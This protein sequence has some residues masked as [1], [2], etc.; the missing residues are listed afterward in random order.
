M[1]PQQQGKKRETENQKEDVA[2]T[3]SAERKSSERGRDRGGQ[4][5]RLRQRVPESPRCRA[6]G[7]GRGRAGAAHP[8]GKRFLGLPTLRS[9]EACGG[10]SRR[11]SPES[12]GAG[13]RASLSFRETGAPSTEKPPRAGHAA[14][15]G[16]LGGSPQEGGAG[17]S[18]R[19][20]AGRPGPH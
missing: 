16:D 15:T 3:R 11:Q 1:T 2:T 17:A 8:G 9:L 14:G 6:G 7:G 4:S 19:Y 10:V 20:V 5:R 13:M 12:V 18:A